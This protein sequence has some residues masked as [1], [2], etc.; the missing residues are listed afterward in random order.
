MSWRNK[1]PQ[2]WKISFK[3]MVYWGQHRYCNVCRN[4]IRCFLPGGKN[5]KILSDLKVTGA[6]YWE[7]DVCPV[8]S[9]SYRDRLVQLYLDLNFESVRDFNI[10]H[11]A[12]EKG[13]YFNM[14]K[15]KPKEYCTGDVNPERYAFAKNISYCSITS[16]PFTNN[17]FDLILCNHVLEHIENDRLAMHELFRVLKPGGKAILQ[18]P[19]AYTL[20][21]T[22]EDFTITD[23]ASRLKHFG[24]ED[25]VRIYGTDYVERLQSAG[26]EVSIFEHTQVNVPEKHKMLLDPNEKLFVSTSMNQ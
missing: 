26:F 14:L 21:K 8:C 2:S 17:R 16:L 12:P 4:N 6:G 25:H 3:K 24:Q 5:E 15:R 23:K 9:S 20:N 18:V 19:I 7:E 10:L 22:I 11:I 1:I 13:L